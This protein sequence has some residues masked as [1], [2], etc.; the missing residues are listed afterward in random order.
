MTA[1][2]VFSTL[3]NIKTI[4]DK[5]RVI[6]MSK[7]LLILDTP[8]KCCRC[9]FADM[10]NVKTEEKWYCSAT[11]PHKKINIENTKKPKFCPFVLIEEED[12]L[13]AVLEVWK[14]KTE[15]GKNGKQK[16]EPRGKH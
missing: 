15:N 10:R 12:A 7:S 16:G 13:N 8:A 4:L 3:W 1:E 2:Q 14:M 11:R 6:V 9:M 5:W